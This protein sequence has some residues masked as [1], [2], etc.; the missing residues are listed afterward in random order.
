MCIQNVNFKKFSTY[1]MIFFV[2]Y[3]IDLAYADHQKI[4]IY[5]AYQS[6]NVST[7]TVNFKTNV[8][9]HYKQITLSA[10]NV[11]ITY[12]RNTRS[13]LTIKA[14]GDPVVLH[15]ITNSDNTIY[16]QS[17]MVYYNNIKN[18]ITFTG[19]VIVE[20]SGNSIQGDTIIYSII[21]KK[22][23]AFSKEKNK[24]ITIVAIKSVSK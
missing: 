2:I 8:K 11:I 17:L 1:Q 4:Q 18:M 24:I 9:L 12:D 19:N 3:F 22:I 23:Q 14:L 10:D 7:S 21:Q 5:S 6:M 20:Q 15:Q 16:A 13:I